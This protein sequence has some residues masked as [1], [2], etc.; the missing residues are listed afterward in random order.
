MRRWWDEQ[1]Q[2][3]AR[4]GQGHRIA[5]AD[6]GRFARHQVAKVHRVEAVPPIRDH[7]G[8]VAIGDRLLVLPFGSLALDNLAGQGAAVD[9]DRQVEQHGADGQREGVDG[10]DIVVEGVQVALLDL[11]AGQR[12]AEAAA[13][14]DAGEG[15]G[16]PVGI[17]Q[18]GG[19]FLVCVKHGCLPSCCVVRRRFHGPVRT[20]P[21]PRG[22]RRGPVPR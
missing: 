9:V 3:V 19:G 21:S 15:H 7:H 17:A 16:A 12:L 10:F 1:A 8:G 20:A 13:D 14:G 2:A 6:D 18:Q 5:I 4:P 11:D 22:R